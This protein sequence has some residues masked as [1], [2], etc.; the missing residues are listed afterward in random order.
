MMYLIL[1]LHHTRTHTQ[2]IGYNK[3]LLFHSNDARHKHT[4]LKEIA[5]HTHTHTNQVKN[6]ETIYP[7]IFNA[8]ELN[9]R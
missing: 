3:S 9:A 8:S 7:R 6:G 4:Q 2:C 1:I 5:T